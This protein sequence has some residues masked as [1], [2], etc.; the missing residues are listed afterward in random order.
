MQ[1]MLPYA[2]P[3][4]LIRVGGQLLFLILLCYYLQVIAH[5]L[6]LI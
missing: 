2:T 6:T 5:F 3:C 4:Y 1:S